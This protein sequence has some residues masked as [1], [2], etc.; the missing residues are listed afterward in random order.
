MARKLVMVMG[1]QRSGTNALFCSLANDKQVI[2]FNESID[3]AI[4]CNYLLRPLGE[5]A[6]VLGA[7][8][9]TVL[10]KPISE[11][12][13]RTIDDVIREYHGY[14]LQI[15]WIYRDPV[16][17]FYS[18]HREGWIPFNEIGSEHTVEHW[19]K[20][21]RLAYESC[22]RY[23]DLTAIVRYEDLLVDRRVFR[24]LCNWLR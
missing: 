14:A 11:T 20:R 4:Y 15:V 17:V 7:A 16:N 5:I 23:S 12:K 18:M 8:T 3:N 22:R 9:G 2:P 6:G 10:L 24:Q 13:Y 1:A 21:N 19:N